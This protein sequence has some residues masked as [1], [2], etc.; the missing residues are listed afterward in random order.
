MSSCPQLSLANSPAKRIRGIEYR[1]AFPANERL[2]RDRRHD[3][4]FDLAI[5]ALEKTPDDALLPPGRALVELAVGR[6]AREPGAGARAARRAVVRV[7]RAEHEV[8]AIVVPT[9]RVPE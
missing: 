7:A 4:A 3:P 2:S 1:S 6:E 9:R 5:R 8:A